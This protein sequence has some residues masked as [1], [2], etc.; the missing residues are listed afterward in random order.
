MEIVSYLV[1]TYLDLHNLIMFHN[2]FLLF[3]DSYRQV[4]EML[5]SLEDNPNDDTA[6]VVES[7]TKSH[8][9]TPDARRRVPRRLRPEEEEARSCA[10][11]PL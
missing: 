6:N 4:L 10:N 7:F 11:S 3:L 1:C 9:A 8:P 2:A 5:R